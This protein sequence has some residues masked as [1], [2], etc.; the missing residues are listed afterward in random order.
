MRPRDF[1][2]AIERSLVLNGPE[3]GYYAGIVGAR[4]CLAAP[5]EPCDLSRGIVTEPGS[6]TITF[7]LTSPDPDFLD[8]L[9][10][11]AAFALPAGT[12]L[13]LREF[14][15]AT[16]PYEVASLDPKRAVRLV[17]NPRFREWSQAAQPSGFPDTIVERFY[18]SPD[19]R[20]AAV[21]RAQPIW[22]R[23]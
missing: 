5:E 23:I 15:P 18:G 12:P 20:V 11:P 16:G 8:K 3:G 10:L 9:A 4:S 19:V 6:D 14:A 13:H 1:R 7:H 22:Q 2:R 17:R 21:V